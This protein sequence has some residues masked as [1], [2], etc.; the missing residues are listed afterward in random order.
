MSLPPVTYLTTDSLSEGVGA[1]QVLA[2][3]E[4]LAKRDVDVRLHSFEKV[5][6]TDAERGRLEES[7]V[8][9]TPHHFGAAGARGGLGRVA[10]GAL[11]IRGAELVHA[12]SDIPAASALVA[13]A[14][15]WVWD[16]RS[17]WGDQRIALGV[18]KAGSPEHRVL[19][20]V[21]K[22][23]ARRSSAVITL[24]E[25]VLPVLADRHGA[26]L[27]GKAEVIPTCV[28]LD[29]FRLA[30]MPSGPA[31]RLLLAGTLNTYYDVD[32]MLALVD[33]GRRR[34]RAVLE[35]LSPAA[36][37]WDQAL[38]GAA[39]QR[40]TATPGEMPARLAAS[41]IG[42]SVC[43]AEAGVSL[44]AAMPTKVAEFLAVGRPVVVNA[45]L[46][47]AD[48]L[49]E[50]ARAGVVLTDLSPDGLERAWDRIE[51]LVADPQTPSRCRALAAEHFD[52]ERGLDRLVETYAR[53][54]QSR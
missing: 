21:E 31:V 4:G 42:L 41:H 20:C 30:P 40:G 6:P 26:A 48:R 22:A 47:D 29:R 54:A 18:L 52:L 7:G 25:A 49:V 32:A 39:A 2:Y 38:A 14:A 45:G 3:V 17:L 5:P 44:T 33:V 1:S 11:A 34:H 53:A 27:E 51:E 50:Q 10:R 16:V 37:Q 35:V 23:A 9:W 28:D 19:Q 13:R 24:T 12:R 15:C 46:G 36:T 8:H 43:R